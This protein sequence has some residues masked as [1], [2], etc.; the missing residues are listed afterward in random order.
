MRLSSSKMTIDIVTIKQPKVYLVT[1]EKWQVS[2]CAELQLAYSSV[3]LSHKSTVSH[4]A[5]SASY[6]KDCNTYRVY[7]VKVSDFLN[8]HTTRT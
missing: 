5:T 3:Q 6:S 1:D 8:N 7:C 4:L 2:G